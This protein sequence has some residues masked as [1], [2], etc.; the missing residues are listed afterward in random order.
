MDWGG[1]LKSAITAVLTGAVSISG[2]KLFIGRAAKHA[3]LFDRIAKEVAV[4]DALL[5]LKVSASEPNSPQQI[6]AKE[7]AY[8]HA[9]ELE[10]QLK[11]GLA[12]PTP[13]TR[14]EELWWRQASMREK[15]WP[16]RYE[17]KGLPSVPARR[18][19]WWRI[20]GFY[21][22]LCIY[23]FFMLGF[24]VHFLSV[25][26]HRVVKGDF[27]G[28][29]TSLVLFLFGFWSLWTSRFFRRSA[30]IVSLRQSPSL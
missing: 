13:T 24:A 2:V 16:E 12:G 9:E 8:R 6:S 7:S 22:L 4:R 10:E 5:K 23:F 26:D 15:L 27:Q 3:D 30:Y 25:T 17:G 29:A 21:V 19:W 14:P 11:K 1:I 18:K 20:M 28:Y